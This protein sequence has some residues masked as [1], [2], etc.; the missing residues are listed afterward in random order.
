MRVR[1]SP[2]IL[3]ENWARLWLLVGAKDAA[4]H[5][6][7]TGIG[8]AKE[9]KETTLED[10]AGHA[11]SALNN[12][13]VHGAEFIVELTSTVRIK[14][15]VAASHIAFGAKLKTYRFAKYKTTE[16][17]KDKPDFKRD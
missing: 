15:A 6:V 16:K 3:K 2:A 17:A 11:I 9:A 13:K 7:L 10:A 5:I 8:T 1:S 14:P 4:S 12:H